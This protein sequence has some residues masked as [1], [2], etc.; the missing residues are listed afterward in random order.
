MHS[1]ARGAG[2]GTGT[3]AG[4]GAG[5]AM[6]PLALALALRMPDSKSRGGTVMYLPVGSA[7]RAYYVIRASA[8]ELRPYSYALLV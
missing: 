1:H 3:G 2:T 8:L 4:A 5:A 7:Y 6:A